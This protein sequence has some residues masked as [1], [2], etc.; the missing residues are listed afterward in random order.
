MKYYWLL[1][2]SNTV[3]KTQIAVAQNTGIATTYSDGAGSYFASSFSGTT[4]GTS[5]QSSVSINYTSGPTLSISSNSVS[6]SGNSVPGG[7]W[8]IK[9]S[10]I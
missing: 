3:V 5:Q 6:I 4:A 1:Q 2:F 10:F 9:L 7:G 8:A